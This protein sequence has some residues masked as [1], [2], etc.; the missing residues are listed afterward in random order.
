MSSGQGERQ[1]GFAVYFFRTKES[2]A[3]T[4]TGNSPRSARHAL[5]L[6]SKL[7]PC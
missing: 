5:A 1:K 7:R 3:V 6:R 2:V 4:P